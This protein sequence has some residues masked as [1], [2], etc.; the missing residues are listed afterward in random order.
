MVLQDAYAAL[1]VST[2]V[3]A[4]ARSQDRHSWLACNPAGLPAP[5][6]MAASIMRTL[7]FA[8]VL[9]SAG[10]THTPALEWPST[11]LNSPSPEASLVLE[12]IWHAKNQPAAEQLQAEL[13]KALDEDHRRTLEAM[14][15]TPRI[16]ES[17]FHNA[18]L[19][20]SSNAVVSFN[21]IRRYPPEQQYV[22]TER[23][24]VTY[25]LVKQGRRWHVAASYR[26][27]QGG[28]VS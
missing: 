16:I 10:C 25:A 22:N 9:V 28:A 4:F 18:V 19:I 6:P 20:D 7:I 27:Y 21:V 1:I 15:E 3:R 8:I 26:Q 24:T 14:R 17:K 12:R 13:L 11:D 5:T 2:S 23:F